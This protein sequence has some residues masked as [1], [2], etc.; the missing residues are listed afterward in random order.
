MI[1]CPACWAKLVVKRFLFCCKIKRICRQNGFELKKNGILWW[2]GTNK[3]GKHNFTVVCTEKSYCVKLVGVRSKSILFGFAD[4]DFYEIK[5]YTF[6]LF[7]TMDGFVYEHRKKEPY[8]FEAGATPCIVMVPDSAKVTA[9]ND[10]RSGRFEIGSGDTT[11]EGTFFFGE[12][13]LNILKSE[14]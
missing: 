5:D 4:K 7:I 12:K 10:A 3:S 1:G 14:H 2:L 9:R 11:P 6:A 8:Q 13:F